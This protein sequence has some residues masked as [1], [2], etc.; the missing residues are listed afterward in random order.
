MVIWLYD[1]VYIWDVDYR[2][3]S[4][5]LEGRKHFKA[6]QQQSKVISRSLACIFRSRGRQQ[7]EQC[8]LFVLAS[9]VSRRARPYILVEKLFAVFYLV[10]DFV[11]LSKL[12]CCGCLLLTACSDVVR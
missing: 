9:K 6:S 1:M 10:I 11:F 12:S 4:N 5:S 3:T 8:D 2:D 7:G